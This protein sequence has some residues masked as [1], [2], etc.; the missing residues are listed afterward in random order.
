MAGNWLAR[1]FGLADLYPVAAA[2]APVESSG[3]RELQEGA[4][5]DAFLGATDPDALLSAAGGGSRFFRPLSKGNRELNSLTRERGRE[6]AWALYEQNPLGKRIPELTRDFVM[7][8]GVEVTVVAADESAQAA[9]QA[10]IDRFWSDPI[11]DMDTNLDDL[12]LDLNLFGEQCYPVAVNPKNGH[13]RIGY[14]DPAFIA[15]VAK[16][17]SG[18]LDHTVVVRPDAKATERK[19]YRVVHIDED[20]TSDSYGRL[21]GAVE[22]ETFKDTQGETHAYDGSCFYF[23][24]NRVKAATTGRSDLLSLIDWVDAYDQML[25][26]EVDRAILMKSFIWD[27]ELEGQGDTQIAEWTKK[28]AAPNPGAIRVHN[29]KVKWEA[30]TPDLKAADATAG[31]DLILDY[32]ATGAGLPKHWLNGTVDVNKATAGEMSEPVIKRL[33]RRQRAVK[34]MVTQMVLFQLDQA[35]LAGALPKRPNV[36]NDVMP[37]AWGVKVVMPDMRVKDQ[38]TAATT[39][40]ALTAALAGA[41]AE[42]IIDVEAAQE[43]FVTVATQLGVEIDLEEL[44]A[45]LE[46][47]E[48]EDAALRVL[49]F[50]GEDDEGDGENGE[51]VM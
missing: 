38:S 4:I 49:P 3:M 37:E 22:G 11:N 35:E 28:N 43:L 29:E 34:R 19:Y 26:N 8:E 21:V 24:V 23:A 18:M 36:E 32:I 48:A 2:P 5:S 14:V 41:I 1:F 51:R 45:R 10:V 50:P 17:A 27:V 33:T 31:A 15:G 44:R 47:T 20:P 7:G 42:R 40:Q 16:D 25:F 6:L 12:V 30:V 39:L 46:K 13:V 9:Q